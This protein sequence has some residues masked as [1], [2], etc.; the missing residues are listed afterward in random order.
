MLNREQKRVDMAKC[1]YIYANVYDSRNAERVRLGSNVH[2]LPLSRTSILV[3]VTN[4]EEAQRIVRRIPGVRKIML[5]FDIDNDLC[6][7]CY[8]CVAA[9]P[10]NSL[11]ELITNWDEPFTTDQY[12][13]RIINGD[14]SANRVDKCR[15]VTGDKNCQTC[16]LAC[17][18]KA[19]TV[20]S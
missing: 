8:N 1:T 17:P 18:F 11:N 12:V 7:G 2:I 14:L 20:K 4:G 15:R 9:C 3:S 5:Q 10:G 13:L 6:N 19:V 16:M